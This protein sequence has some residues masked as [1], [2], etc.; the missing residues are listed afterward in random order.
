[1]TWHD[2]LYSEPGGAVV[3]IFDGPL[4]A[5][6]PSGQDGWYDTPVATPWGDVVL[7]IRLAT[8]HAL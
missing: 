8:R 3:G 1:M 6:D 4:V 2:C 5:M 7:S